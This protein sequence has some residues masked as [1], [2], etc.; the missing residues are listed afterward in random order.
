MSNEA[1]RVSS[2]SHIKNALTLL[3]DQRSLSVVHHRWGEQSQPGVAVF[4]VVPTKESLRKSTAVLDAPEDPGT[5]AD[6]SWCGTDFPNR[7]CRP[8]READ[9]ASW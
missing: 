5:P 6:T 4:L 3:E 9:Y 2:I 7:G 8:R 1:F